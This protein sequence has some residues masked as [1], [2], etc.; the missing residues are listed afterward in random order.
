MSG[1]T[2]AARVVN[3]ARERPRARGIHDGVLP[4]AE[5]VAASD[6]HA[7]VADGGGVESQKRARV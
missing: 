5:E 2:H 7:L 6:A 1:S 4:E 3:E